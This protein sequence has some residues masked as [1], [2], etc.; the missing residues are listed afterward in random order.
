MIGCSPQ[1]HEGNI[2]LLLSTCIELLNTSVSMSDS[3]VAY[4]ALVILG[5][6]RPG[7][8]KGVRSRRDISH[9]LAGTLVY[10]NAVA[11]ELATDLDL[12]SN[13]ERVIATFKAAP[14]AGAAAAADGA[15]SVADVLAAAQ[16]LQQA[17]Q[18]KS[19]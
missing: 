6:Q 9:P 17:T 5:V 3:T 14:V 8:E 12:A 19:S 7:R 10:D 1:Q 4:R 2:A 16:E 11:T 15:S 13:V 18:K